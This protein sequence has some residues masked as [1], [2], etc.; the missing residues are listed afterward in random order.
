M[1]ITHNTKTGEIIISL[2]MTDI[3]EKQKVGRSY[4]Q[5]NAKGNLILADLRKKFG[6]NPFKRND[7]IIKN[8]L[9]KHRIMSLNNVLTTAEKRGVVKINR[10]QGSTRIDTIQIL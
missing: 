5:N 7:K 6:N 1:K 4:S 2:K 10:K 3:V 9:F 8:L